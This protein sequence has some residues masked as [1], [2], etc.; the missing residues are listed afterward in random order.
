MLGKCVLTYITNWILMACSCGMLWQ[1]LVGLGTLG[2][3]A[4]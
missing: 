4:L 2:Q 1:L 3:I